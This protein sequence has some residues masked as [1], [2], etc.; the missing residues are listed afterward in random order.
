MFGAGAGGGGSGV[1]GKPVG[2][3]GPG[4]GAGSALPPIQTKG[5]GAGGFGG[6]TTFGLTAA[7]PGA[8]AFG[9]GGGSAGFTGFGA[10][11]SLFG[12]AA[13]GGAPLFGGGGAFG[14][15]PPA[16]PPPAAPPA[17]LPAAP[18]V[19][20]SSSSIF[21]LDLPEHTTEERLRGHFGRFG[22]VTG[23]RLL[24]AK[25][26]A[27][28]HFASHEQATAAKTGGRSLN[29]VPVRIVWFDP[30][31][32]LAGGGGG[33]AA[34]G[35]LPHAGGAGA[36]LARRPLAVPPPPPD[37][38]R[39]PSP[40]ALAAGAPA[41]PAGVQPGPP[42][43][44]AGPGDG[45]AAQP[46]VAALPAGGIFGRRLA[47]SSQPFAAAAAATRPAAG[48]WASRQQAASDGDEDDAFMGGGGERRRRG[49]QPPPQAS[50]SFAGGDEEAAVG[51]GG[52][53]GGPLA[54]AQLSGDAGLPDPDGFDAGVRAAGS[55]FRGPVATAALG[56]PPGPASVA[57]NSSA[58]LLAGDSLSTDAASAHRLRREARFGA[59]A[60]SNAAAAPAPAAADAAAD[61]AGDN[62][63]DLPV[64]DAGDGVVGTCPRMCPP[65]DLEAR[66]RF[67]EMW[68][69]ERADARTGKGP[70][71]L[72]VK[73]F[74]RSSAGDTGQMEPAN[75]RPPAVLRTT[76]DYLFAEVLD[77][78]ARGADPRFLTDDGAPRPPSGREI[79]EFLWNRL[80]AVARDFTSQN[81]RGSGRNDALVLE[82]H[83]RMVRCLALFSYELV[84]DPSFLWALN[85]ER[86]NAFLKTLMELYDD[87]RRRGIAG[88]ATLE[89]PNVSVVL[90]RPSSVRAVCSLR[91][92]RRWRDVPCV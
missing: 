53:A 45:G 14:P 34:E 24:L 75:V 47:S 92:A 43:V 32:G 31:K 52:S 44:A 18:P 51:G 90:C 82:T 6:A 70:D 5:G 21:V 1:F 26:I 67:N 33:G 10:P 83:E 55:G 65:S 77:A 64:L 40:T 71:T 61:A 41:P 56:G 2:W 11:T 13:G 50:E 59:M 42:W 36:A 81:Y 79:W 54:P 89:S 25:R 20:S 76:V 22:D 3:A 35:A 62:D 30:A 15:P 63:A 16:M 28:V 69:F 60:P 7:A 87:A 46:P 86:L 19:N 74:K 84:G 8:A 91:R 72:A 12:G 78:D 66:L 23:V 85:E 73:V 68:A 39:G 88:V 29:G 17:A 38:S 37:G 57:S 58:A 9:A 48:L 49:P 4:E 27:T 80:R